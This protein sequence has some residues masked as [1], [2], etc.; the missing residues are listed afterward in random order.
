MSF[1]VLSSPDFLRCLGFASADG[2]AF[3]AFAAVAAWGG[4]EPL[5]AEPLRLLCSFL[6]LRNHHNT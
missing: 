3:A 1:S 4:V 6:A 2:E 5:S